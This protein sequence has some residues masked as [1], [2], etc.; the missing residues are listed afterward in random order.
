MKQDEL[1]SIF[2]KNLNKIDSE[3]QTE[4]DLIHDVVAE[5]IYHLM[6]IGN[7]PQFVLSTLEE[8]LNEEVIEIYRKTTYGFR[9][10]HE[11]KTSK[12]AKAKTPRNT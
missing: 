2:K 4:K 11:F 7:I 1:Y 9:S 10:L 12:K 5:Y 6:Q 8:D 3:T